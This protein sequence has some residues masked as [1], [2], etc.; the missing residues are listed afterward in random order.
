MSNRSVALIQCGDHWENQRRVLSLA[1]GL[2]DR[3]WYP[4][5]M[6]Y[7]QHQGTLFLRH[8]I[9]VAPL[10]ARRSRVVRAVGPALLDTREHRGVDVSEV[11][12]VERARM[13][14]QLLSARRRLRWRMRAI[15]RINSLHALL[16]AVQ[17]TRVFV[18]NGLTGVVANSLRQ[19]CA[20]RSIPAAFLER[21]L[22]PDS[23][24]VDPEGTNAGSQ[25]HRLPL[26]EL[27]ESA[28][29]P[30]LPM[31]AA[32]RPPAET[33]RR[34]GID[35]ERIIFVPL[36]VERDTNI[37]FH[38]DEVKTMR[39]LIEALAGAVRGEDAVVIARRH[40]EEVDR[41][42]LPE[43]PNV[44]YIDEGTVE[45][46]CDAADLVVTV[47]STVGL[48][49]LMRGRPVVALGRA[50][51]TNKGLCR[52]PRL[53]DLASVLRDP[54]TWMP[55]DRARVERFVRVL[56]GR[57]TALPDRPPDLAEDVA[58]AAPPAPFN[59]YG[60]APGRFAALWHSALEQARRVAADAGMV[61]TSS[62][63]GAGDSLALTYRET[64]RPVDRDRLRDEVAALLQID[65][66]CVRF[67]TGGPNVVLCP[68]TRH[69]ATDGDTIL[70]LDQYAQP[71]ARWLL[72]NG[73]VRPK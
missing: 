16:D 3:G 54:Y 15:R 62:Q 14:D 47:S 21:G 26:E 19:L 13:P 8:R 2:A 46:W 48:T 4:V 5:V 31:P 70:I 67:S 50:L 66:G 44:R 33:R 45:D 56:L 51:Y 6:T 61:R 10:D 1:R 29:A 72:S 64:A 32:A 9:D 17:P 59:P 43:L 55:P 28:E 52:E 36:Q 41:V 42:E 57:H 69:P 24:F 25:L 68:Q 38:S 23:V 71:H 27:P 49:A 37:L 20:A 35:A 11:E 63:L 34:H 60:V 65:A 12:R 30:G 40:P 73:P 53:G 58:P 22:L 18:W 39:Q 7:A